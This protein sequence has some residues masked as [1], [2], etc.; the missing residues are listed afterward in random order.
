MI[1]DLPF[2]LKQEALRRLHAGDFKAA[3]AL[4]DQWL[5]NKAPHKYDPNKNIDIYCLLGDC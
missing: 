5:M 3:K 2:S 1:S 4:H